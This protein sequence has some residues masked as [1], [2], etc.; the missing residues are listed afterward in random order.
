MKIVTATPS[1]LP[2]I[3]ALLKAAALPVAGIEN[4]VETTLVARDSE[5][6]L[7]CAAVEVYGQAGLLRSVAVEVEHRGEG[8]GERLT[9]GARAR[10]QPRGSQHLPAH[11]HRQSFLS[12]VRLCR[13]SAQRAGSSAG[14]I[15]G[16]TRSMPGQRPR[17]A[18]LAQYFSPAFSA[19]LFTASCSSALS[20]SGSVTWASTNMSPRR[21]F[22]S[23][24]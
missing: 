13:D 24:P 14:A 3:V 5:R 10:A 8:W 6:L 15:R 4:H 11:D 1:D 20:F 17:D 22:F 18:R 9:K 19:K 12:A 7:G 16:A 23:M 21:P 2:D